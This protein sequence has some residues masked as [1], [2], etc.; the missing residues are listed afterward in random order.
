VNNDH[1]RLLQNTTN[2]ATNE[3]KPV[4]VKE[5][6]VLDVTVLRQKETITVHLV[7]LTNPMM[8]KGPFRELIPLNAQQVCVRIP[9]G[10]KTKKVK[11]LVNKSTPKVEKSERHVNLTFPFIVDHIVVAINLI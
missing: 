9:E 3:E 6:G 5:P 7:N 2:W 4:K 1:S 8:M 10:R 11:P